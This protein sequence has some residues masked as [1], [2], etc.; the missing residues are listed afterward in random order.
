MNRYGCE[1][2][3][4]CTA[5]PRETLIANGVDAGRVQIIK[6]GDV[7]SI[8]AFEARVIKGRHIVFD[9]GL[10]LRTLLNPRV[11]LYRRNLARLMKENKVYPEA[12]ET[13][14]FEISAS[15]KRALLFGS[16]NM[17]GE[18]AYPKGADLLILPFQGHSGMCRYAMPF[19]ERLAPQKVLLTHF[20]DSFPPITS[21]VNPAPFVAR[22]RK[23]YPH[24][25]V[26]LPQAGEDFIQV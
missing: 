7:L 24:I 2:T 17:D 21:R 12:G 11:L 19:I 20:D 16:L 14:V 9:A 4:Y 18:T 6:P 10:V 13:V 22:M 25:P 15:G 23:E 8:G 3:V 1:A 5:K 26:I